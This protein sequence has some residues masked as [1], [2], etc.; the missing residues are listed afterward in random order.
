[1]RQTATPAQEAPEVRRLV[2]AGAR[3]AQSRLAKA[4]AI[5][6]ALAARPLEE[7]GDENLLQMRAIPEAHLAEVEGEAQKVLELGVRLA[8]QTAD[9]HP[10]KYVR[11]E[12]RDR[13]WV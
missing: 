9:H 7:A 5:R 2:W 6:W 4:A 13:Q 10:R 8:G 11:P 3:E 1:M 12:S